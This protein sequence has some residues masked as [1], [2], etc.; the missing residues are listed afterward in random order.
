MVAEDR[1]EGG[2][3]RYTVKF[4]R[5]A[6]RLLSYLPK[7][8]QNT[9]RDAALERLASEPRKQDTNRKLLKS[10][11]EDNIPTEYWELRVGDLRNCYEVIDEP[12]T[13][14]V[15]AVGLK[16]RERYRFGDEFVSSED[17]VQWLSQDS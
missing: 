6:E 9:A 16:F 12:S 4:T 1:V 7:H 5:R 11:P 14:Y 8:R 17:L 13:V 10:N 3:L 15:I 2:G